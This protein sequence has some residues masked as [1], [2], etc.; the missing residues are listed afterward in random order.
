M[1]Y[2]FMQNLG[3]QDTM[4]IRQRFHVDLNSKECCIGAVVEIPDDAAEFLS[5]KYKALL[6]TIKGVA[7]KEEI[8][9]PAE[10][11]VTKPANAPQDSEKKSK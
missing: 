11:I 2:K 6:E 5:S 10:A 8:S 3:S 1:Q 4:E 7:K 9:A